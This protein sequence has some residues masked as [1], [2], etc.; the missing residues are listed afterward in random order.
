MIPEHWR[1]AALTPPPAWGA[2][3][4]SGVLRTAPEDFEVD[5]IL[6]FA[7]GGEGPHA[8][9]RVRKRG[10]NTEWVARELARAAGVKP[11]EVGF[12][13]LKDRNAVTTQHFTVPRGKRAAEEFAGLKGEGYEVLSAAAHQ[14]KL[15][16][17]ALEGNR[18]VITVRGLACDPAELA[19]RI[20]LI[21]TGGAPNYFGEQRFGREAGNL[22]QV[23]AAAESL[24]GG[25]PPRRRS[26]DDQTGFMLSAARSLIFNAILV[27]RIEQGNWNLLREGDVANLDGRGSVFR[28]ETMDAELGRRCA[29]LELHPSGPLPGSEESMAGGSVLALEAATAAMFPEA[30]HVIHSHGMKGERRALRIRVRELTHD[31]S[32]DTL[33]LHFALSAGSFATTVLREIIAGAATGE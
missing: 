14:R 25:A 23:M 1:R 20:G 28:V 32:G 10:A 11:F 30:M 27:R 33:R 18:F 4:G 6:G 7:A 9:L 17:G 12:A 29:A 5:E 15:P 13:G 26:R 2:A 24:V 3:L 31:Y 22:A 8:L 21:A 16:R 19:A